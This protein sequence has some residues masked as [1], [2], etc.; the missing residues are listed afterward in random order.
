MVRVTVPFGICICSN[1]ETI[2]SWTCHVYGPFEFRTSLG[3]SILLFVRIINLSL[4]SSVDFCCLDTVPLIAWKSVQV[5]LTRKLS[6]LLQAFVNGAPWIGMF[7]S[8]IFPFVDKKGNDCWYKCK[9]WVKTNMLI[10]NNL[11]FVCDLNHATIAKYIVVFRNPPNAYLSYFSIIYNIFRL[12]SI[13]FGWLMML[14]LINVFI[15]IWYCCFRC[16]YRI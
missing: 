14:K 6:E 5:T 1:V 4:L 12:T 7:S 11:A 13:I 16:T 3:T 9:E 15:L 2:L 8:H 10:P